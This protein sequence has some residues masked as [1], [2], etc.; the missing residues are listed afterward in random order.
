MTAATD[1][2]NRIALLFVE[3]EDDAREMVSKVVRM[4][5]PDLDLY[6]AE[7][8]KLGMELFARHR[9]DIVLTDVTMPVMDGLQMAHHIHQMKEQAHIL[10]M[11]AHTKTALPEAQRLGVRHYL[12]KPL[13]YQ[14]L[15]HAIEDCMGK[16]SGKSEV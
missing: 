16:L 10:L 6:V 3:D 13:V 12:T 14:H 2:N 4:K 5:Y 9:P 15:F 11:T 1:S 7:N 8:G